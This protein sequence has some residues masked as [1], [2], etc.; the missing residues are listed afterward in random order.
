[1]S[2]PLTVYEISLRSLWRIVLLLAI[3]VALSIVLGAAVLRT[4][5]AETLASSGSASDLQRALTIDPGNAELHRQVGVFD[6]YLADPPDPAAALAHLHRAVELDPESPLYWSNLGAACESAGDRACADSAYARLLT[7]A[8][9][10]PRYLWAGANYQLRSGNTDE[11]LAQFRRLVAVSSDLDL[12]SG[13]QYIEQ[14]LEICLRALGDPQTIFQQVLADQPRPDAKL[15][16]VDYLSRHDR[17]DDA[18]KVWV[19]TAANAGPFPFVDVQDY[20]GRLLI[21]SRYQEAWGVWKDLLRLGMVPRPPGDEPDNLV[22]NGSFEAPPLNAGF[23]WHF[24][25]VPFLSL[26]FGAPQAYHGARCLRLEFAKRNDVFQPVYEFVPVTPQQPYVLTAYVRSENITSDTGPELRVFDPVHPE[27]LDV[28]TETT[29]ATT[30]WHPVSLTFRPGP[31][32]RFVMLAIR[33]SRGRSFPTEIS[34][35]FWVDAISIKPASS[36]TT[37]SSKP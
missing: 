14:T 13:R 3:V 21:Q 22:F 20:L 10:T 33:R 19:K 17:F 1:M 8:P 23:D 27:N 36:A 25:E 4:G 7:L 32:T 16:F 26:D 37:A 18:Y 34:G 2:S 31:D 28:S 15:D 30:A 5:V 6:L 29:V 11:A 35:T 12:A 9:M 24:A